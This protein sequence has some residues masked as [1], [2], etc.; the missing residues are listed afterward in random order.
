M[1]SDPLVIGAIVFTIVMIFVFK[2]FLTKM[3]AGS[4]GEMDDLGEAEGVA[5]GLQSK[6]GTPR[7]RRLQPARGEASDLNLPEL[8]TAAPAASNLG[9]P[10]DSLAMAGESAFAKKPDSPRI[11][12]TVLPEPARKETPAPA[13]AASP[14][15]N[16]PA[17]PEPVKGSSLVL[18]PLATDKPAEPGASKT[19]PPAG[20]LVASPAGPESKGLGAAILPPLAVA[21]ARCRVPPRRR[22]RLCRE[23]R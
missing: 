12:S 3:E 19:S 20:S 23:A 16:P 4:A 8:N 13:T 11:A 9:F 21:T 5:D 14:A 17:G 10:S 22:K 18:P 6:V 15:K 2:W 7:A 1:I